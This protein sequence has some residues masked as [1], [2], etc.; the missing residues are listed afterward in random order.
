ML[1][2]SDWRPLVVSVLLLVN[3]P[4]ASG[5]NVFSIPAGERI[6]IGT[7]NVKWLF[8]DNK[9]DNASDLAKEMSAASRAVY[10]A[11]VRRMAD[12]IA[13]IHPTVMAM[14]E[15]ES[16]KVA[17]DLSDA[18]RVHHKLKPIA[19]EANSTGSSSAATCS[20]GKDSCWSESSTTATRCRADSAITAR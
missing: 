8:D 13:G 6:V 5:E 20:I 18:L 2:K 9:N 3:A 16:E 4:A 14:Q 12:V 1:L 10:E 15:I 7:W 17:R 19:A 11:R